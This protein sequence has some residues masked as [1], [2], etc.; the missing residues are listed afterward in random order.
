MN[1]V[2]HSTRATIGMGSLK[3]LGLRH[4]PGRHGLWPRATVRI[5]AQIRA[6]ALHDRECTA[7]T[8]SH[9]ALTELPRVP[10]EHRVDE[11]APDRTEERAIVGEAGS[12]LERHRQ[13]ELPER[14][15]LGQDLD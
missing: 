5:E 6:H 1:V 8:T 15:V 12:E 10:T 7:L 11:D 13:H 3:A 14:H 2:A 4:H 9:A